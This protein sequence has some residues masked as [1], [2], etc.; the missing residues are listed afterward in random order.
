MMPD[1][2]IARAS[3][4]GNRPQL[5]C[6]HSARI[7]A[8]RDLLQPR[9]NLPVKT[10]NTTECALIGSRVGEVQNRLRAEPQRW[11]QGHIPM[12]RRALKSVSLPQRRIHSAYIDVHPE[13]AAAPDLG[14]GSMNAWRIAVRP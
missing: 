12:Q 1:D 4:N 10:G 9:F 7:V 14:E 8:R 6:R 2:Q 11:R 5:P 3:C 13:I